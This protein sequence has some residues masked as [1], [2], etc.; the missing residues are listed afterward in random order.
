MLW[1]RTRL[2]YYT[3]F[4]QGVPFVIK[5]GNN[6]AC[7]LLPQVQPAVQKY[8]ASQIIAADHTRHVASGTRKRYRPS[9]IEGTQ[10]TYKAASDSMKDATTLGSPAGNGSSEHNPDVRLRTKGCDIGHRAF[11]TRMG[12]RT[13]S[14]EPGPRPAR[15]YHTKSAIHALKQVGQQL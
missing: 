10:T 13:Q 5:A 2:I 3:M 1:A 4:R 7:W 11:V 14:I 8:V 6:K 12:P 15:S 9:E